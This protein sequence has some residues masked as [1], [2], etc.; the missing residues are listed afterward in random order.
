MRPS[1]RTEDIPEGA[2]VLDVR[3]AESF[4]E[5]HVPRAL[6]VPVDGSSFATKAAFVLPPEQAVV[7]HGSGHAVAV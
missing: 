5:G 4:A 1:Q 3:S 7:L 2:V 6:N